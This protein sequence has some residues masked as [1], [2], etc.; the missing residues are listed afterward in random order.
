MCDEVGGVK[1]KSC[2]WCANKI[3]ASAIYCSHCGKYQKPWTEHALNFSKYAGIVSAIFAGLSFSFVTLRDIYRNEFGALSAA[4][5][6]FDI[7][8]AVIFKNDGD[9]DVFISNVSYDFSS[10]VEFQRGVIPVNAIVKAGELFTKALCDDNSKAERC[11]PIYSLPI[12]NIAGEPFP[13]ARFF[14]AASAG[15][16]P[17]FRLKIFDAHNEN[18]TTIYAH[19]RAIDGDCSFSYSAPAVARFEKKSFDC[20]A[21]AGFVGDNMQDAASKFLNSYNKARE[22]DNVGKP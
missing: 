13:S 6:S 9:K 17:N 11:R 22:S 1:E 10:V 7:A 19:A 15:S 16:I 4:L 18:L 8:D 20:K 14:S 2:R 5:V 3:G 21:L 12:D